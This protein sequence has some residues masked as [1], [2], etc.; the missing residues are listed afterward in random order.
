ME[1]R[2]LKKAG[3]SKLAA[4]IDH[5]SQ[6]DGDGRGFDILSFEENGKERLIEVKTTRSRAE[7]PFFV[8][9]NELKVSKERAEI[10]H[11]VRVFNFGHAPG[12]FPLSGSLD[13]T[14]VLEPNDFTALP[15][16]A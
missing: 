3:K 16:P 10:Y 1:Y 7:T 14:S 15:K 6:T 5:V 9:R 12:W 4:R 13:T 8:S 2:R 11:L